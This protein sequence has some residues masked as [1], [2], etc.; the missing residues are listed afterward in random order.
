MRQ[1]LYVIPVRMTDEK[2]NI[3][4][5]APHQIVPCGA[6]TRAGIDED[7][8][9]VGIDLDTGGIAPVAEDVRCGDRERSPH[10]PKGYLHGR[11]LNRRK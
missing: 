3:I 4:D 5:F 9:R 6:D 11:I 2:V 8:Q 7:G 10:S 1:P